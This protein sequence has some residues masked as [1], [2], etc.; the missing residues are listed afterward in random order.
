MFVAMIVILFKIEID[1]ITDS[2]FELLIR[3]TF[4]KITDLSRSLLENSVNTP[5]SLLCCTIN[6]SLKI[7]RLASFHIVIISC[8]HIVEKMEGQGRFYLTCAE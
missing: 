8:S 2:C 5:S 6:N 3:F 7:E 1:R 4:I